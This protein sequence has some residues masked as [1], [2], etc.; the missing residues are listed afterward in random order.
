MKRITRC[1]PVTPADAWLCISHKDRVIMLLL[2]NPGYS[3]IVVD[4]FPMRGTLLILFLRLCALLPLRAAQGLGAMVARLLVWIPN[5]AREIT[6]VNLEACLPE[7]PPDE[8]RLLVA[9]SLIETGKAVTEMGPVWYWPKARVLGLVAGCSGREAVDEAVA[10]GKGVIIATPHLGNWEMSGL[11]CS[12]LYTMTSLY[13]P[14]RLREI[15]AFMQQARERVGARLV[16]ANAGGVRALYRALEHGEAVGILPDQE[17]NRGGGIFADFF[18]IPAY[19]MTLIGRLV[20][21]TGAPV[22][23]TYS[24]RLPA[25]RGFHIHFVPAPHDLA[26]RPIEDI[27]TAINAIAENCIRTIPAQYQWSY[28][29]FNTRPDG[30]KTFY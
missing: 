27:T 26:S 23:F 6:R 8:R 13:R 3:N 29:R 12:S 24:E 16:P 28:K 2:S 4:K 25:G 19:T 30:S 10:R 5:R 20:M 1:N 15:D 21:R 14:P 17:P 9:R 22:F 11:Y 7:L 18:G